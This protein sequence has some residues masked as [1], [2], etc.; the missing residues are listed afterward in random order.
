M[1]LVIGPEACLPGCR[2]KKR[3]H[4]Q[5]CLELSSLGKPNKLNKIT[6][7]LKKHFLG[8][9]FNNSKV[10]NQKT[11]VLSCAELYRQIRRSSCQ[12]DGAACK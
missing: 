2:A 9:I 7:Q 4:I 8:D 5:S 1:S 6:S 10:K 12:E 11:G 3:N